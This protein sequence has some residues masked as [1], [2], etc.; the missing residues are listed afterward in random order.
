MNKS[1]QLVKQSRFSYKRPAHFAIKLFALFIT[2][3]P[4]DNAD[5]AQICI[6]HVN[7]TH[8]T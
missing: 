8:Q 7:I 2:S 5:I 1:Y 4:E 3:N 6:N